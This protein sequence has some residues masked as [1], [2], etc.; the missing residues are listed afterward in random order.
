MN[1]PFTVGIGDFLITMSMWRT[2]SAT[3]MM[4][5]TLIFHLTMSVSLLQFVK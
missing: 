4:L 1:C 2:C 3:Q 5:K